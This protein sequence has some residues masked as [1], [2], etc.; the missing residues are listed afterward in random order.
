VIGVYEN[1]LEICFDR[2]LLTNNPYSQLLCSLH[3]SKATDNEI[4]L[5][6]KYI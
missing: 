5:L 2:H 4:Y 1:K 3:Q 6:I